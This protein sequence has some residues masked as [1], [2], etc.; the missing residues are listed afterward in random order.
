MTQPLCAL[1]L[2]LFGSLRETVLFS[3]RRKDKT[4]GAKGLSVFE[5]DFGFPGFEYANTFLSSSHIS[6]LSSLH[7]SGSSPHACH[8]SAVAVKLAFRLSL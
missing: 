5:A 4:E 3:Q 1:S 6:F 7:N 8:A 2:S